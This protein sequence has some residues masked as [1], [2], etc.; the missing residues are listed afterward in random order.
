MNENLFE[1]HI[2]H[3]YIYDMMG[4]IALVDFCFSSVPSTLL[5]WKGA[6][7]LKWTGIL[8]K[9]NYRFIKQR[10]WWPKYISLKKQI[11][12]IKTSL[13]E[14]SQSLCEDLKKKH[15]FLLRQLPHCSMNR[16]IL[17]L[18]HSFSSYS[19][20]REYKLN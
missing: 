8:I 4:Y 10:L 19:F 13:K 5:H 2:L 6:L 7:I 16:D 15:H 3:G 11:L 20:V 12:Y 9:W 1:I 14:S 18:F 17:F